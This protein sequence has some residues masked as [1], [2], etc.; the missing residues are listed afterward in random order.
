MDCLYSFPCFAVSFTPGK[1]YSGGM[2]ALLV[3]G[4]VLGIA[5]SG[6]ADK[7]TK[8][9]PLVHLPVQT[10]ELSN[11]NLPNPAQRC[12][13]WAWAV[14][15]EAM[16]KAQKVSLDQRYWVRK[17]NAG[18]VCLETLPPVESLARMIDGAYTLDD[19]R[20]V[21]LETRYTAGAPTDP[22]D[23]VVPLRENRP[24]LLFWKLHA[25]VVTAVTY[26]E[27]IYPNNQRMFEIR[28]IGL[29]DPL[30][31]APKRALSFTKG[32]DD[33]NDITGCLQ[34]VVT[35]EAQPRW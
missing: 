30:E 34:I 23:L 1:G 25:Y 14:A 19:G 9:A 8:G 35:V 24:A 26:D 13:N 18:E 31:P 11:F 33:V 28:E 21:R 5:A 22:G 3:L 6:S 29:V 17:A 12:A 4:L 2:R 20:K 10:A 16:L 32:T 7:K 27:Y 15:V